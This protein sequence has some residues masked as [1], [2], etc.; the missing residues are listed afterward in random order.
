MDAE[1][2][3]SEKMNFC[4]VDSGKRRAVTKSRNK[5][6]IEKLL[7]T[8]CE[9]ILIV[10]LEGELQNYV[11]AERIG[12]TEQHLSRLLPRLK[13]HQLIFSMF[14]SVRRI[15]RLT[16]KGRVIAELALKKKR[17]LKEIEVSEDELREA[18]LWMGK[19]TKRRR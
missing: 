4:G 17:A 1:T 16:S 8:T 3:F 18:K 5:T 14:P 6:D 9:E 10:L 13:D 7:V 11:L 2:K 12:I 15:N 19:D